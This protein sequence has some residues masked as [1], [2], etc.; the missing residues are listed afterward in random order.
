MSAMASVSPFRV[1]APAW[2]AV[3][4]ARGYRCVL[5]I[6]FN[7]V[8]SCAAAN[9]SASTRTTDRRHS[10]LDLEPLHE[11]EEPTNRTL[12]DADG[13]SRSMTRDRAGFGAGMLLGWMSDPLA[14]RRRLRPKFALFVQLTRV[15]EFSVG[16]TRAAG[17][18]MALSFWIPSALLRSS[19][20]TTA[21]KAFARREMPGHKNRP[22]VGWRLAVISRATSFDKAARKRGA[23]AFE[24]GLGLAGEVAVALPAGCAV[25]RADAVYMPSGIHGKSLPATVSVGWKW[26]TFE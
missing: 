8:V 19:A 13:S 22:R 17:K 25:A 14:P 6:T 9:A 2:V 26:S 10:E 1:G 20:W 24:S 7:A 23:P 12:L 11:G 5:V 15:V 18:T 4:S 16:H 3:A 21:P